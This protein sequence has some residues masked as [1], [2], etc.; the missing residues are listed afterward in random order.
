MDLKEILRR[1]FLFSDD[2]ELMKQ[3]EQFFHGFS[4]EE[5][6]QL[7]TEKILGNMD[8]KH[9]LA[10]DIVDKIKYEGDSCR[11][12][13]NLLDERLMC[14]VAYNVAKEILNY[15]MSVEQAQSMLSCS[16]G[17]G[18][19][20]NGSYLKGFTIASEEIHMPV[21]MRPGGDVHQGYRHF[22]INLLCFNTPKF[23]MGCRCDSGPVYRMKYHKGCKPMGIQEALDGNQWTVFEVDRSL[24][25]DFTAV[26]SNGLDG[27][28]TVEV[29]DFINAGVPKVLFRSNY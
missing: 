15:S 25:D 4:K 5:F 22:I 28:G 1:Y 17:E 11:F 21:R 23:L 29:C 20:D 13:W 6:N 8:F 26:F 27:D 12:K 18:R 10:E 7:L 16:V 3:Y 9:R 2:G 19:V 14:F 24:T